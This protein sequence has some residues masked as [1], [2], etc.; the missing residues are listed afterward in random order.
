MVSFLKWGWVVPLVIV[1]LFTLFLPFPL[2]AD[3]IYFFGLTCD[4]SFTHNV[5][6]PLFAK[7]FFNTF[8]CNLFVFKLM[9]L[10]FGFVLIYIIVKSA[11]L[12]S[13]DYGFLSGY[14]VFFIPVFVGGLFQFE[15]DLLAL[16]YLFLSN[17]FFLKKQK[18]LGFFL[19][20]FTSIFF[21][22]GAFVYVLA[23]SFF[24]WPFL[25]IVLFFILFNGFDTFL[26]GLFPFSG[27]MD[28]QIGLALLNLNL[29]WFGIF[30]LF[31]RIFFIIPF[32]VL[33]FIQAKFVLHLGF[34]L[35]L[36]WVVLIKL[37]FSVPKLKILFDDRVL[38]NLPLIFFVL[39][40]GFSLSI[41]YA[42]LVSFP[43]ENQLNG[44]KEVIRLSEES[45]VPIGND[46][47]YGY[48]I[49]F[50]GGVPSN[51]GGGKPFVDKLDNH[52]ILTEGNLGG[53]EVVESFGQGFVAQ[54]KI[55]KCN[56]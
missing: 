14:S 4:W 56:K 23:Y 12:I 44:V 29:G 30:I 39:S 55:F 16:P 35:A 7:D 46:W 18:L 9:P 2:G 26:G 27:V 21:W 38:Q 1:W 33:A 43:H 24:Y 47:S 6:L 53:C 3:S 5:D 20:V 41:G 10:L 37:I 28:E 45:G 19:I 40:L 52:F 50:F 36:G 31:E 51:E 34:W 22:K 25:V 8:P 42:F 54:L 15:D 13:R 32:F 11:E 17:Y 48:L 49:R